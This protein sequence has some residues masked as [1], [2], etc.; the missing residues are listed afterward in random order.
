MYNCRYDWLQ[1]DA[2]VLKNTRFR[3][4]LNA[5]YGK[6]DRWCTALRASTLLD[7]NATND[8]LEMSMRKLKDQVPVHGGAASSQ[9]FIYQY[10]LYEC[11]AEKIYTER[12][13][14]LFGAIG[15]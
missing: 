10:Y 1:Y 2:L 5:L 8:Y 13:L 7:T 6:K 11:L 4:Q 3:D 15:F 9:L 14:E 12:Y